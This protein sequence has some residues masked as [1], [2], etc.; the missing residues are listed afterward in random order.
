MSRTFTSG[1]ISVTVD[2]RVKILIGGE[3]VATPQPADPLL[4]PI[5]AAAQS[6]YLLHSEIWSADGGV[7]QYAHRLPLFPR[8]RDVHDLCWA[9][10]AAAGDVTE[11]EAA[12]PHVAFA[13]IQD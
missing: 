8:E 2:G 5:R 1:D 9:L 12:S 3:A 11:I 13:Q 4:P 10:K 6:L 7:R